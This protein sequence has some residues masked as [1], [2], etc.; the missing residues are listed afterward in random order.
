MPRWRAEIIRKK[1]ERL[2]TVEAA[3]EREAIRK[4]AQEYEI[5]PERQNRLVVTKLASRE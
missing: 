2:G 3:S 4:A 5:P 1:A